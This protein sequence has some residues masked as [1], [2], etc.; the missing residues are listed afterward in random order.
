VLDR[1][2]GVNVDSLADLSREVGDLLDVHDLF[3]GGYTPEC[4]SPGINRP[5]KNLADF[6]RFCGK[7]VRLRTRAPIVG[8]RNFAGLLLAVDGDQI[9]IEDKARGKISIPYQLVERAN[10]EHDFAAELRG[11]RASGERR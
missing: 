10:Y 4:S 9:E 8:A 2:G 6:T 11:E 3:P 1:P 5:L 7:A